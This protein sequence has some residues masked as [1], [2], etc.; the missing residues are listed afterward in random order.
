MSLLRISLGC[1]PLLVGGLLLWSYNAQQAA[2]DSARKKSAPT[3]AKTAGAAK[4]TGTITGKVHFKGTPPERQPLKRDT[5]PLCAKTPRLSEDVVVADGGLR[6]V[7]VGIAVGTAG[8]HQAPAAPVQV[9]QHQCMYE[10][11]VVGIIAGQD[12]VIE[13]GDATYHNVRGAKGKRTLWNLSQPAKAPPLRRKNLGKP[14]EVVSLHCDVHPWMRAYAVVSDH[15]FFAVTGDGGEFELTDVPAG[16]YQLEAWH[17]TLG[18]K[19]VEVEVKAGESVRAT[20]EF[21][22]R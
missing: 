6:D 2:A 15:P 17:A 4:N 20:F 22:A 18:K 11:R 13:N 8:A 3:G 5:D 12:V 21:A 7:H 16:T 1:V 14:G 9:R 19:T 10:P